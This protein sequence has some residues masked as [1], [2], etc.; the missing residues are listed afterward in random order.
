APGG[1]VAFPVECPS[2]P[3]WRSGA[4]APVNVPPVEPDLPAIL[5]YATT[6]RADIHDIATSFVR[7]ARP[8]DARTVRALAAFGRALDGDALRFA[9]SLPAHAWTPYRFL[10]AYRDHGAL[11]LAPGAL[12]LVFMLAS[13]D[14]FLPTHAPAPD[15]PRLL[16]LKRREIA[17]AFGFPASAAAVRALAKVPPRNTT[18]PTLQSLRSLLRHAAGNATVANLLQHTPVLTSAVIRVIA[19]PEL[20]DSVSPSF[21]RELATMRDADEFNHERVLADAIRIVL[22]R[23]HAPRV[24]RDLVQLRELHQAEAERLWHEPPTPDVRFPPSPVATRRADAP[25]RA[26]VAEHIASARELTREGRAMRNCIGSRF[27]VKRIAAGELA[28]YRILAPSRATLTLERGEFARWTVAEFR[29]R[30]N[31]APPEETRHAVRLWLHEAQIPDAS[32]SAASP[33]RALP[34][35]ARP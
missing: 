18:V 13:S 21:L 17:A 32:G 4:D 24:F 7:Q 5:R 29:G 16:R 2:S 14:A 27:Y 19:D 11:D 31:T 6:P 33:H 8:S 30:A 20:R 10:C 28:A 9:A 23:D 3:P 1:P 26:L 35:P 34:C 22:E 12:P 15:I 25:G